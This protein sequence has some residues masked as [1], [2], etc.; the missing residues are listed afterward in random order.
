MKDEESY[1]GLVVERRGEILVKPLDAD[2]EEGAYYLLVPMTNAPVNI[3]PGSV[4]PWSG[5][6]VAE[7]AA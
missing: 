5:G 7:I 6:A 4:K 3:E 1:I 2:L